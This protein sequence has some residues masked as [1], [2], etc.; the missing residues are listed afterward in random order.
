LNHIFVWSE[1]SRW[2]VDL[3]AK[4]FL[5]HLITAGWR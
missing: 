1:V 3:G 4:M 5:V 2:S